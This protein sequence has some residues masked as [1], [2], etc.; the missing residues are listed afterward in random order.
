MDYGLRFLGSKQKK[1]KENGNTSKK[2]MSI[3]FENK[4]IRIEFFFVFDPKHENVS[5]LRPNGL[6]FKVFGVKTKKSQRK[7]EHIKETYEH[8]I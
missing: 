4:D 8:R 3:V 6:W 5:F 1:I 2:H 7:R